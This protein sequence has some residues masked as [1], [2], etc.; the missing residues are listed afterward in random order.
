MAQQRD[1]DHLFK[2][3]MVGDSGV[4]KTSLLTRYTAGQYADDVRNTVGVDL[5]VKWCDAA[6]GSRVK[7]TIWD[8]AGQERFRTLTGSYYRGAHGI[9]V[10]YDVT[11]RASFENVVEWLK[12][13]DIYSTRDD[14]VKILVGNKNDLEDQ[15]TVSTDEGRQFARRH[16]MLFT[17]CSAKDDRWVARTFDE[18][19][20]K[21][22]ESPTLSGDGAPAGVDVNDEYEPEYQ[23]CC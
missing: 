12:E 16:S 11:D 10:A 9:V 21:I 4:G 3:L 7:L 6:D 18:L 5:K 8:T 13:I 23:P 15:R 22:I 14:T 2:L 19:V 20:A 1:Y 17:E